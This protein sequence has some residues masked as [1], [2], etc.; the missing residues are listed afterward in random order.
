[1]PSEVTVEYGEK[2]GLT[3]PLDGKAVDGDTNSEVSGMSRAYGISDAAGSI[4]VCYRLEVL[5]LHGTANTADDGEDT[6]GN[7]E[8][9]DQFGK[10]SI[11]LKGSRESD[12][13]QAAS[14]DKTSNGVHSTQEALQL[15]S[16]EDS[17]LQGSGPVSKSS[18]EQ[19]EE[20][21]DVNECNDRELTGR[22]PA[23]GVAT[24]QPAV[25]YSYS[26]PYMPNYTVSHTHYD[27]Q[28][29]TKFFKP[30]CQAVPYQ[31]FGNDNG[32]LWQQVSI[33]WASS[34]P[35]DDTQQFASSAGLTGGSVVVQPTCSLDQTSDLQPVFVPVDCKSPQSD[36]HE[37]F[38]EC[39]LTSPSSCDNMAVADFLDPENLE[40]LLDDESQLP[41]IS[42]TD[43]ASPANSLDADVGYYSPSCISSSPGSVDTAICRAS[44]DNLSNFSGDTIDEEKLDLIVSYIEE[45]EA[46]EKRKD[47]DSVNINHSQPPYVHT[48]PVGS[49]FAYIHADCPPQNQISPPIS[50]PEHTVWP[51]PGNLTVRINLDYSD[52]IH[53][54]SQEFCP[55]VSVTQTPFQ[56]PFKVTQS[57]TP[58]TNRY[59]RILPKP[60]GPSS[61]GNNNSSS[62]PG[63]RSA[64]FHVPSQ[65]PLPTEMPEEEKNRKLVAFCRRLAPLE[66]EQLQH[67]DQEGDTLLHI[68]VA[69]EEHLLLKA[70]LT[71]LDRDA[72]LSDLINSRNIQQHTALY[73]AVYTN[74]LAA[75]QSL[76]QWGADVNVQIHR[77]LDAGYRFYRPIHCAASKGVEWSN[78]LEELLKSPNIDVHAVNSEGRTALHCAIEAH[79]PLGLPDGK[80]VDSLRNIYL[81]AREKVNLG[82]PD[83]L[84]GRTP[85]HYVIEKKDPDFVGWFLGLLRTTCGGGSLTDIVNAP[86]SSQWTALRIAEQLTIDAA[87]RVRIIQLLL[88][89]GADA[90]PKNDNTLRR[91]LCKIPQI[92]QM[93]KSASGGRLH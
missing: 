12:N 45:Q 28:Q 72:L 75:V 39:V 54:P 48:I 3:K 1:M 37:I 61:V 63:M 69:R 38:E 50:I 55:P 42:S 60:A 65:Y 24:S 6:K 19:P 44:P 35:F 22:G 33:N 36:G 56:T 53:V 76:I 70:L 32:D 68:A 52:R 90:S 49:E 17:E 66:P 86:T 85:L 23:G 71:R 7:D 43:V 79:N 51:P 41:L 16:T 74:Q 30:T 91:D 92:N 73:M 18:R 62:V 77:H 21:E 20:N 2:S 11:G 27:C 58:S 4:D 47:K 80:P 64:E 87:K 9:L 10:L 78:V 82:K 84:S 93:L 67:R 88:Q 83:G 15:C 29:P 31:Y 14:G 5:S 59:P 40:K 26:W 8:L 46:K 25:A 34:C 89:H 13:V 57:T 81:L